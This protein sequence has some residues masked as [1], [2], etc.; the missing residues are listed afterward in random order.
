MQ[1]VFV[2]QLCCLFFLSL[3]HMQCG[4]YLVSRPL[5]SVQGVSGS[6]TDG[7]GPLSSRFDHIQDPHLKGVLQAL[8][9]GNKPQ[10]NSKNDAVQAAIHL[11]MT[12]SYDPVVLQFLLEKGADVNAVD[13]KGNSPLMLV[14]TLLSEEEQKNAFELLMKHNPKQKILV[15]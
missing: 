13:S 12:P 9:A 11:A 5:P 10:L 2:P 8:E 15:S 1:R 4:G 6:S 3:L 7:G 14:A